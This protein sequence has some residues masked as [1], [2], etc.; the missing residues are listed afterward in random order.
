M[1]T[2]FHL[3]AIKCP[4][5][6]ARLAYEGGQTVTC[7]YCQMTSHV[8]GRP[9]PPV[10]PPPAA[11]V[12]RGVVVQSPPTPEVIPHVRPAIVLSLIGLVSTA[13]IGMAAL[14][15]RRAGAPPQQ[16]AEVAYG[17]DSEV[18]ARA[19]LG[20]GEG[21]SAQV[22]GQHAKGSQA[23][24]G[25]SPQRPKKKG[26]SAVKHGKK[27]DVYKIAKLVKPVLVGCTPG[28]LIASRHPVWYS[29]TLTLKV[30]D[31]GLQVQS[32]KVKPTDTDPAK[33]HFRGDYKR[34]VTQADLDRPIRKFTACTKKGV[35]KIKIPASSGQRNASGKIRF[36]MG[37]DGVAYGV[38]NL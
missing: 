14:M 22:P 31:G 26:K 35:G 34:E 12:T 6:G 10:Q 20:G 37:H 9:Q 25:P 16:E 36:S 8:A 28:D 27:P 2:L 21:A 3:R 19:L 38:K 11:V 18:Q 33:I 15:V 30:R 13:G 7:E 5:C 32:M 23:T 1:A 4:G 24:P 17:T 29:S